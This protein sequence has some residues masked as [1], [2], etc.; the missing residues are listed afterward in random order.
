MYWPPQTPIQL[1]ISFTFVLYIQLKHG[2]YTKSKSQRT[3]SLL[4]AFVSTAYLEFLKKQTKNITKVI[5]LICLII[6][7]LNVVGKKNRNGFIFPATI[8]SKRA[9][10]KI[11]VNSTCMVIILLY[12][13]PLQQWPFPFFTFV[14]ESINSEGFEVQAIHK[15]VFTL[16]SFTLHTF[17]QLLTSTVKKH[18]QANEMVGTDWELKNNN[19]KKKQYS[20]TDS[21]SFYWDVLSS[22]GVSGAGESLPPYRALS[23]KH[24]RQA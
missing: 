13:F 16:C 23:T 5:D 21:L 22:V 2:G 9:K 19:N 6:S 11:C 7:S 18:L 4:C 14:F 1:N 10:Y 3:V 15:K 20:L 12:P 17:G 8:L 24:Q